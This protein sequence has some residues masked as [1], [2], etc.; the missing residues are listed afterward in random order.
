MKE[1]NKPSKAEDA[2]VVQEVPLQDGGYGVGLLVRQDL[3]VVLSDGPWPGAILSPAEAR[4]LADLLR[5]VAEAVEARE[6]PPDE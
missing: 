6:A 3:F 4:R 1:P 5:I 2:L